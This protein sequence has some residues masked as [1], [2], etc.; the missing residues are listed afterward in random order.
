MDMKVDGRCKLCDFPKFRKLPAPK[1]VLIAGMY[2]FLNAYGAAVPM[3]AFS[4]YSTEAI[5]GAHHN[6]VHGRLSWLIARISLVYHFDPVNLRS[7]DIQ[8]MFSTQNQFSFMFRGR[9]DRPVRPYQVSVYKSPRRIPP[10]QT[11]APSEIEAL[12]TF[13]D[14]MTHS[15][16]WTDDELKEFAGTMH[17]RVRAVA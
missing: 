5:L 9:T 4:P 12:R 14:M 10:F 6:I 7:L 17:L 16:T 2:Y 1:H 8:R 15:N 13:M 11:E 3:K